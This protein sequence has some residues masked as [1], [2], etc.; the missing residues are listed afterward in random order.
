MELAN[1]LQF[2]LERDQAGFVAQIEQFLGSP[3]DD[4]TAIHGVMVDVKTNELLGQ[5]RVSHVFEAAAPGAVAIL[6]A[7]EHADLT[8]D[9]HADGVGRL[10]DLLGDLRVSIPGA[11]T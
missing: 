4:V 6:D 11:A 9:G 5:G 3:R 2:H 7:A 8:F 1:E 10:D